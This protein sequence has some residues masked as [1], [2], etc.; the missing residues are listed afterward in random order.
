MTLLHVVRR[1]APT[2]RGG[3]D[4]V[5][6]AQS[7]VQRHV[8]PSHRLGRE[9][10]L[11]TQTN[12]FSIQTVDAEDGVG[13]LVVVANDEPRD[14]GIDHLGHRTA[15]IG[16][17]RR[18]AGHG[19]DHHQSE[20]LRPVDREQQGVGPAQEERTFGGRRSRR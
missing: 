1:F 11:E 12:A 5:T 15:G 19:L 6:T 13:G 8:P 7:F 9:P 2:R 17:D 16:H 20:R 14:A 10:F 18:A 3:I 4:G